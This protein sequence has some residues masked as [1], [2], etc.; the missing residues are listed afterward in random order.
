MFVA[1]RDY[2]L[3]SAPAPMKIAPTL[4]TAAISSTFF[5]PSAV[6]IVGL[7][8]DR[9]PEEQPDIRM[10]LILDRGDTPRKGLIHRRVA[11]QPG[12]VLIFRGLLPGVGHVLN[13]RVI[14]SLLSTPLKMMPIKPMSRAGLTNQSLLS[15]S[16]QYGGN[17]ANSAARCSSGTAA[18][19]NRRSDA[20]HRPSRFS[21]SCSMFV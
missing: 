5:T 15:R 2:W 14:C 12:R 11:T 18:L 1:R 21:G 4:G 13:R 9:L 19:I 6:S 8:A 16:R 7:Q 3:K 20:K 10:P 17:L